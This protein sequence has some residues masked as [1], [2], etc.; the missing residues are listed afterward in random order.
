[1]EHFKQALVSTVLLSTEMCVGLCRI[2]NIS[3]WENIQIKLRIWG[4]SFPIWDYWKQLWGESPFLFINPASCLAFQQTL[5]SSTSIP[6]KLCTLIH[7]FWAQLFRRTIF[8]SPAWRYINNMKTDFRHQTSGV[9]FTFHIVLLNSEMRLILSWITD[10]QIKRWLYYWTRRAANLLFGCHPGISQRADGWILSCSSKTAQ[11]AQ[12]ASIEARDV[13]LWPHFLL[14]LSTK[15]CRTLIHTSG[16]YT[17]QQDIHSSICTFIL[18]C[19]SFIC[20]VTEI[21]F[22]LR[23]QHMSICTR[24]TPGCKQS[25]AAPMRFNKDGNRL[26]QWSNRLQVAPWGVEMEESKRTEWNVELVEDTSCWLFFRQNI[27]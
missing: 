10:S 6:I 17:C 22:Q 18:A 3:A 14:D 15:D 13:S 16:M 20:R 27:S 1:M 2:W 25:H 21:L 23:P 26:K 5:D 7:R 11:P 9:C 4:Q 24:T 12:Q 19:D 8:C